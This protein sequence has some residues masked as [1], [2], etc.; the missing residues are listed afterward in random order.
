[1]IQF[2][3]WIVVLPLAASLLYLCV[4]LS[5]GFAALRPSRQILPEGSSVLLLIPAHNEAAGIGATVAALRAASPGSAILVVA[6]NCDDE[7]AA[8]ARGAGAAVAERHDP[9]RRGKGFALAH[10]RDHISGAPPTAVIVVD[11]DCR[12]ATG[13]AER[14]AT[15]A[16][17]RGRPVQAANLLTLEKGATPLMAVSNFA[18]LIKNLVRARG[19]TRLGGGALLF[20][21]GMAFPW[22][23]FAELPL[24][25][26]DAVEDLNLGLWLARRGVMVDLDDRAKVTSPGASMESSRA[27]RSRW[28]HGFLGTAARQGLPMLLG[29][30]AT[31][32]RHRAAL[33]AHLLVPPLALLVLL[34]LVG[35]AL[36]GLVGAMANYWTPLAILATAFLLA[37]A[38]LLAAWW[39]HGRSELPVG[40]LMRIPLYILWKIPIYVGFFTRR[41]TGW[42]RTRR[43]NEDD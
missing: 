3:A 38:L 39:R 32:S 22:W 14:L 16:M 23:L 43:A 13:S 28:E 26:D 17:V 8:V 24:A 40:A 42:N 19:L 41:Q 9:T 34:S 25:T 20:G 31:A 35:L 30:I 29:G 7:T 6:D 2:L 36:A 37:V 4:E 1:M 18:M 27:Q 15:R 5:F 33:G 10:G 21:T 12:L 11:A